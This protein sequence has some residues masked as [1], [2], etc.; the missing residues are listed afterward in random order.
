[1]TTQKPFKENIHSTDHIKT[2]SIS[3]VKYRKKLANSLKI[4]VPYL[5]AK[6]LISLQKE[7]LQINK[8]KAKPVRIGKIIE[9]VFHCFIFQILKCCS[10]VLHSNFPEPSLSHLVIHSELLPHICITWS[11]GK[12]KIKLMCFPFKGTIV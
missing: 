2:E 9:T 11:P 4:S 6:G 10:Q 7:L 5:T 8:E 12:V 3:I 1:M